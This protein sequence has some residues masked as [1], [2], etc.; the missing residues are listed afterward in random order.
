MRKKLPVSFVFLLLLGFLTWSGPACGRRTERCVLRSRRLRPRRPQIPAEAE[1]RA[2]AGRSASTG[3]RPSTA[4]TPRGPGRR[5][6]CSTR[7]RSTPTSRAPPASEADR[8]AAIEQ[9][10]LLQKRFPDSGYR[11]RAGAELQRLTRL[12]P[13]ARTSGPRRRSRAAAP[14]AAKPEPERKTADKKA[15]GTGGRRGATQD[16]LGKADGVLSQAPGDPA[17]R[18]HAARV[19]ALH[20]PL[21]QRLSGGPLRPRRPPRRSTRKGCSTWRCTRR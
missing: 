3:S 5:P 15:P 19:D 11:D 17:H 7:A 8:K 12:R 14:V 10:E 2:R 16:P 9:F 18:G 4:R 13:R 1:T 20:R 6:A 21:P